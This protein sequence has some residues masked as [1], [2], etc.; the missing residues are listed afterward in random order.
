MTPQP[1]PFT[2]YVD[3][4]EAA[5]ILKIHPS[6]LRRVI[7]RGEAPFE[8]HFG[9]YLIKRDVLYQFA[10]SYGGKPGRKPSGRLF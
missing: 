3:L 2:D 10:S 7:W 4:V 8:Q 9:K 6:S 1:N 5:R